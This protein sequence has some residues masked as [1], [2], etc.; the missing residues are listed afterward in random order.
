MALCLLSPIRYDAFTSPKLFNP[1][2]ASLSSKIASPR[3]VLF[4]ASE[5]DKENISEASIDEVIEMAAS[6]L[7]PKTPLPPQED[8]EVIEAKAP[9]PAQPKE[10]AEQ[11]PA[12]KMTPEEEKDIVAAALGGSVLGAVIGEL[13]VIQFPDVDMTL[14]P[15]VAP[16]IGALLFSGVGYAGGSLDNFVG[17]VIRSALG[18][19]TRAVGSSIVNGVN[20]I[21]SR[22][23]T[24]AEDAVEKTKDDI[25]AI[26]GK[27]G[28]SANRSFE[29]TTAKIKAAPGQVS[30]AAKK[31][32]SEF[33]EEIKA[34]PKRVANSTKRAVEATVDSTKRALEDAVDDA[35]DA[36][37]DAVDEVIA[38]PT[39]AVKSVET[40]FNSV[41]GK[42][43]K[44]DGPVPP[45]I[46]PPMDS[47]SRTPL[48]PRP[49]EPPGS[50]PE[51]LI[52]KIEMLKIEMPK[53]EAPKLA[54]PKIEVPKFE[55]P[56]PA[57]P[58][59]DKAAERREEQA[60]LVQAEE[61]LQK[62]RAAA[63]ARTA[64][65]KK[66]KENA[67]AKAQKETEKDISQEVAALSR[68][69]AD[70]KR[71]QQQEEKM[72]E[73]EAKRKQE[74]VKK[75]VQTA[76][77]SLESATP[78][79]TVSLGSLFNFG[80][81]DSPETPR[82]PPAKVSSAPR[83]VPTI[84]KWRQNNDGSITGRISGSSGF[85]DGDAVTT[86]SVSKGAT[87]GMVVQTQSGSK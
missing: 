24:A 81:N 51:S 3:S 52:P 59:K 39:K 1:I 5:D 10:I 65:A 57:A 76:E 30:E 78:R 34:T 11:I 69:L 32:A 9:A 20:G 71:R 4:M 42:P 72:A 44:P 50:V 79:K 62:S 75:R 12:R 26:P 25:K 53:I 77:K 35:I 16:I 13:A 46:P 54:M 63:E 68:R 83:G 55:I 37:E 7:P 22:A 82:P 74:E 61:Q 2:H 41:I 36:V 87:S 29:A 19:T 67:E 38:L 17:V 48:K 21:I 56:K 28:D 6:A 23:V 86:S 84:S 80:N 58:V 31:K 15:V 49:P 33:G 60:K 64:A 43:P 14:G 73:L 66:K 85:D 70:E 47:V 27:F 18:K 8:A 45:K 40:S